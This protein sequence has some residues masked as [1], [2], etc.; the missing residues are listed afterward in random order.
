[1]SSPHKLALPAAAGTSGPSVQAKKRKK[2]KVT[3]NS[4]TKPT[5]VDLD[6]A[7]DEGDDVSDT[8]LEAPPLMT[9]GRRYGASGGRYE[10]ED[11]DEDAGAA[12]EG[13]PDSGAEEGEHENEGDAR[14]RERTADRH[15]RR[16][17][18]HD[19]DRSQR[20]KEEDLGRK[21]KKMRGDQL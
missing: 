9:S 21:N 10:D 17:G 5:K 6:R 16:R 4:T 12:G 18:E 15:K 20:E 14:R 3:T 7:L 1:M 2:L 11:Y 8:E 19:G 13:E